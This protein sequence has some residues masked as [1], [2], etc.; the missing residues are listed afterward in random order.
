MA[1]EYAFEA[2]NCILKDLRGNERHFGGALI[3]LSEDL[4]LRSTYADKIN[5]CLKSSSFIRISKLSR[6]ARFTTV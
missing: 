4:Y 5:T 2:L 1:H 6:F 3:I